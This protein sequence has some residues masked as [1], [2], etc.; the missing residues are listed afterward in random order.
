M[1][2]FHENS[3]RLKTIHKFCKK[4]SMLEVRLGYKYTLSIELLLD[5]FCQSNKLQRKS[6]K[7]CRDIQQ[8][9]PCRSKEVFSRMSGGR[10][11][12]TP[13]GCP[14]V[15]RLVRLLDVISRRSQ[16]VRTESYRDGQKGSLGHVRGTLEGGVLPTS[17]APLFASW[18][19]TT[20]DLKELFRFRKIANLKKNF[21]IK[22][23]PW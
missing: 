5:R 11:E 2:L 9:T 14:L 15:V 8:M 16:D 23:V 19:T 7:K 20:L 12:S 13:R 4:S 10:P 18:D 3:W 6:K 22:W 1:K 17:W 21:T